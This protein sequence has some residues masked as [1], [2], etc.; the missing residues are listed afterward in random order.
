MS[1]EPIVIYY[2]EDDEEDRTMFRDCLE[3]IGAEVKLVEFNNGIQLL[4]H[5]NSKYKPSVPCIIV[6]DFKMPVMDGPELL[7][8]LKKHEIYKAIPVIMLSTSSNEFDRNICLELGARAFFTKP[9]TLNQI[10]ATV[11]EIISICYD[12]NGKPLAAVSR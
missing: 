4:N 1:N 6:S 9:N 8:N 11:R 12:M 3:E 2:A 5:L 7:K 10:R